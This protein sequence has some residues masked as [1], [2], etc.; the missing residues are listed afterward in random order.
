MSD[1]RCGL[2]LDHLIYLVV[3]CSMTDVGCPMWVDP[4]SFVLVKLSCQMLDVRW[5]MWL[6]PRSFD[7]FS[8][9]ML[10]DRCRMSDVA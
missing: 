2:I 1:G 6:E 3:G 5:P 10:D 8:C 7:L 4:R 9:Q